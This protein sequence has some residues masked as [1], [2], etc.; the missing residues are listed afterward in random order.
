[1]NGLKKDLLVHFYNEA[2]KHDINS[3]EF[4]DSAKKVSNFYRES[5]GMNESWQNYHSALRAERKI[6]VLTLFKIMFSA[7][8]NL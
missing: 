8:L 3:S 2:L 1:M 5:F 6:E 7:L 4:S